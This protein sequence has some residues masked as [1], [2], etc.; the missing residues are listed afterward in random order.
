MF[1]EGS[2]GGRHLARSMAL[3]VIR[4]WEKGGKGWLLVYGGRLGVRAATTLW[5]MFNTGTQALDPSLVMP[6][7]EMQLLLRQSC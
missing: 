4:L 2:Q 1:R 5:I 6:H 7:R 3:G